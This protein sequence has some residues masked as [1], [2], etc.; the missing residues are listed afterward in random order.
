MSRVYISLYGVGLGHAS[1]MLPVANGLAKQGTEVR[2]S[3]FGDA[4]KYVEMHG[5]RCF[6]VPPV[7]FGWSPDRGFTLTTSIKKLPK[8]FINYMSQRRKERRNISGFNPDVV[9]S[10]TR[11]S[12]LVAAKQLKL[13]V[14]TIINQIKL[15]LSTGIR[16]LS[17][18]RSF[19]HHL[20][21]S[22]GK[23]W[24]RSDSLLIPDLPPPYTL[25]EQNI[26]GIKSVS[27]K[28]EY[29]GFMAPK[30]TIQEEYVDKVAKLLGFDRSKPIVFGHI[31]GPAATKIVALKKVVEA[32]QGMEDV[33]FVVSEGRPKG[34]TVPRRIRNSWYFEWCPVKD[35]VFAMSDL[36]IMRGGH[37]VLAQA[38]QF[39]KPVVSIPIENHGE[40]LGN[41]RKA[42]KMGLGLMLNQKDL[43]PQDIASSVQQ[44]LNDSRYAS[45]ARMLM[46]MTEKMDGTENL[47]QKV[48]SYL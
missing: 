41:A 5:Y 14:I 15:L 48:R 8:N 2:F 27:N 13:P 28:L 7:E 31:S 16:E 9:V 22:L 4:V 30:P 44:V 25:S 37:S 17:I 40:Q 24:A 45:K 35:E 20:A 46:E 6:D 19:E 43:T 21:E 39:G 18:A 23:R 29:I 12:S 42:E 3:T 10:D 33:Q 38:M 32:L 1:R 11:L 36:L 26:W 34:D 47:I